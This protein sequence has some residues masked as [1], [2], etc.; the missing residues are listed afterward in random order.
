M[1]QFLIYWI[2]LVI[3]RAIQML[4]KIGEEV[5]IEPYND[6]LSLRT[7]NISNSAFASV[8]FHDNY[9]SYYAFEDGDKTDDLKCKIVIRVSCFNT[10]YMQ[11][12]HQ[13]FTRKFEHFF[14][15]CT[16]SVQNT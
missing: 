3:A 8:T 11:F 13:Y 1:F 10:V 5:F 16:G 7:V 9:F 15:E 6:N 14:P 12:F 2:V 4:S